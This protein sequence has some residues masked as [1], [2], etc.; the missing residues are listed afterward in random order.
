MTPRTRRLD[1]IEKA[2]RM[3]QRNITHFWE[4]ETRLQLSDRTR[5]KLYELRELEY[6]VRLAKRA[7]GGG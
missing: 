7:G 3:L 2:R 1:R 6:L 4:R 5:L